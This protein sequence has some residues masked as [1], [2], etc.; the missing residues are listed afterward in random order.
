MMMSMYEP[1]IVADNIDND[2]VVD[3][4]LATVRATVTIEDGVSPLID[5][6]LDS[7]PL[8]AVTPLTLIAVPLLPAMESV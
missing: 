5:E 4:P 1:V 3:V 6:T 2:T 8:F 7:V